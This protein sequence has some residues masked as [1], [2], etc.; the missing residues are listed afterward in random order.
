MATPNLAIPAISS[1]QSQKEVTSNEADDWLDEATQDT[2]DIVTTAGG[3]IPLTTDE[4]RK[5][6]LIRLTGTPAGAFNIDVP[7]GK[8]TFAIENV[9]GKTATID[10]VTGGATVVVADGAVVEISSKGT[11]LVQRTAPFT[12]DPGFE[13]TTFVNAQPVAGDLVFKQ[14][15]TRAFDLPSGLTGSEAHGETAANLQADFDILK[16]G[17]S[18]GTI[19]FAASGTVATFIMSSATSFGIGDR[20][21]ITAPSP[22]DTTLADIAISLMGTLP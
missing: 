10:T 12:G 19:R 18:V 13:A 3:T 4:F 22:Q 8:R 20:L 5:N 7:D 21:E 16:N 9:S 1:S 11:D 6:F 2:I 15:F 14:V 17:V